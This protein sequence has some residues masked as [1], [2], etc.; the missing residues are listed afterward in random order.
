MFFVFF[1]AETHRTMMHSVE[2]KKTTVQRL[3]KDLEQLEKETETKLVD[4]DTQN[5]QLKVSTIARKR[6]IRK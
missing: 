1:S 3:K 4:I 5:A 6:T 2:L